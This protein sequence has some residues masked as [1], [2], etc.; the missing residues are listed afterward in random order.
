MTTANTSSTPPAARRRSEYTRAKAVQALRS[1][2]AAGEPVTFETVAKRAG[3]SRSWLYAQPDLRAEIERLRAAHRRD[4]ASPF[5]R[6]SAVPTLRCCGDSKPPTPASG[7]SPRRTSDSVSNS[8]ARSANSARRRIAQARRERVRGMLGLFDLIFPTP[9]SALPR[10]C[11]PWIPTPRCGN[12]D[13]LSRNALA[14]DA[15]P[16]GRRRCGA[17]PSRRRCGVR[18]RGAVRRR[19]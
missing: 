9:C 10:T 6:V 15:R 12:R 7:A 14:G 17:G 3:V 13:G 1:L 19:G 16:I 18:G 11:S 8:P 2:D 5:P 4:P